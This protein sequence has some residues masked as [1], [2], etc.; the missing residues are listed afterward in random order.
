MKLEDW[1]GEDPQALAAN[2][3][4]ERQRRIADWATKGAVLCLPLGAIVGAV[5]LQ[6]AFPKTPSA[7][8]FPAEFAIGG[9]C[10]VL[11]VLGVAAL[12]VLRRAWREQR[13]ERHMLLSRLADELG[14]W[15]YEPDGP[16]PYPAIGF[17]LYGEYGGRDLLIGRTAYGV[18]QIGGGMSKLWLGCEGE[19]PREVYAAFDRDA[20]TGPPFLPS[21]RRMEG[22]WRWQGGDG[23]PEHLVVHALLQ[24]DELKQYELFGE[25]GWVGLSYDLGSA[26]LDYDPRFV[27]RALDA[28]AEFAEHVEQDADGEDEAAAARGADSAEKE[29]AAEE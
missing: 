10:L 8:A 12:F 26:A 16:D 29:P 24:L 11:F 23:L 18:T 7:P 13:R 6:I 20:R 3:G 2:S 25:Q 1:L 14:L 9:A 27:R 22:G 15:R 21:S 17:L 4:Y 28:L 5:R 19:T